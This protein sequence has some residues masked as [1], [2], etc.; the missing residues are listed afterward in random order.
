MASKVNRQILLAARPVGMVKESDFKRVE[1]PI[2]E[3]KDGE[4]LVRNVYLSLDPTNRGWMNAQDTYMP[5]I[6][7]G[8]VI[9]GGGIGVVEKSRNPAYSAGDVVIGMIGW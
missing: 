1:P 9:R 7:I 6:K 4:F 2:P 3:P 8:E 5:A